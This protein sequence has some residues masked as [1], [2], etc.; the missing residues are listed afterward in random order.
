MHK[1][2]TGSCHCGAVRYEA[3]IDLS[4][5]TNKCNCSIC[6]KTRNW[7]AIIAPK[8]FR[9]LSGEQALSDYQFNSGNTHHLFCK[10]CGVRPFGRGHV[11]EI[12]GDYVAVQVMTLDDIDLQE[13]LAAPVHYADGRHD[14]WG[15]VP[16]E[17]RHL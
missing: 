7:N 5:G 17:T 12:G 1:T 14:N 16:E 6:S 13:L 15:N 4:Q 10:H 11:Q 3:E 8:A 2:Y 9:L